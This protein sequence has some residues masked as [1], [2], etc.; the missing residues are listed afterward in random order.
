M[1]DNGH[2]A[3]KSAGQM[4]TARLDRQASAQEVGDLQRRSAITSC[5][6]KLL[7]IPVGYQDETGFHCGDELVREALP[8]AQENNLRNSNPI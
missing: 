7:Q 2:V 6:A 8:F 1:N 5:L 4:A 3:G